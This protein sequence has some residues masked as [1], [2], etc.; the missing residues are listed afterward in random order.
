L[1]I[2]VDPKKGNLKYLLSPLS[3]EVLKTPHNNNN[4]LDILPWHLVN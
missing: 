1:N 4:G 3:E 2:G